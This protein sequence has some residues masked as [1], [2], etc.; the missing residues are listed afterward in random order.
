M[1]VRYG[2]NRQTEL[3]AN[4]KIL[5]HLFDYW[6]LRERFVAPLAVT[7]EGIEK[8]TGVPQK[9]IP[10]VMRKLQDEEY[11]EEKRA[12]VEGLTS[13]R[14]VY[15]LTAKGANRGSKIKK[16][17]EN[18]TVKFKDSNGKLEEITLSDVNKRIEPKL[19]YLEILNNLS[20]ECVFDPD[21]ILEDSEKKKIPLPVIDDTLR[22]RSRFVGRGEE[23][24]K[25]QYYADKAIEGHGNLVFITGEAGIGKTRLVNEMCKYAQSKNVRFLIGR[26]Q[27]Q[28]DLYPYMPFKQALKQYFES[29]AHS[30]MVK[31]GGVKISSS[32]IEKFLLLGIVPKVDAFGGDVKGSASSIL[33]EDASIQIEKEKMFETISQLFISIAGEKPLILFLDDLHDADNASLQ[34]LYYIAR[35]TR[36]SPILICCAYRPEDLNRFLEKA[37]PLDQLL[38]QMSRY[39]LFE[40][41]ALSRL[42]LDDTS[43]MIESWYNGTDIPH[44]F[45]K[46]IYKETD[47]NPFFI[48]EVLH[49]LESEGKVDLNKKRMNK[50]E[51]LAKLE[52]PPKIRDV[53]ARR[54]SR[55]DKKAIDI[56]Q[57]ASV[58]G[59]EFS[60]DILQDAAKIG[61]EELLG[62][63]GK[64]V[65]AELIQ[66][67]KQRDE[68]SYIFTHFKIR[69][70]VYDDL[71]R[72]E[73]LLMHEQIGNSIEK[74]YV[75]GIDEVL[76]DLSRHF[77]NSRDFEKA[78]NY[79]LKAGNKAKNLYALNEA[80]S[81]YNSALG[82][83]EK[84]KVTEKNTQKKMEILGNI[85]D[86]CYHLGN[87]D[88]ALN[89]YRDLTTLAN[90]MGDQIKRAKATRRIGQINKNKGDWKLAIKSFEKAL[91][92]SEE[93]NDTYG[94]ADAYAGIGS[95]L[96]RRGDYD[97]AIKYHEKGMEKAWEMGD[98]AEMA[99]VNIELGNV[100]TGKG[101][102]DKAIEYFE[103]CIGFLEKTGDIYEMAR[104]Y[105]NLGAV[106]KGKEEYDRAIVY[107]EK[108]VEISDKIGNLRGTAYGLSNIGEI[109]IKKL[110]SEK[111]K[112]YSSKALKLFE[113]LDDK[114]GVALAHQHFASAYKLEKQWEK[115]IQ[116]FNESIKIFE[117]LDLLQMLAPAYFEIGE[118]HES[119]RNVELGVEYLQKSQEIWEELGNKEMLNE[120]KN[121]LEV[122][123]GTSKRKTI[124]KS[125]FVGRNKEFKELTHHLEGALIGQGN[126]LFIEGEAG[127]GKSRLIEEFKQKCVHSKEILFLSGRC[128][129][130]DRIDPYL[131]FISALKEYIKLKKDWRDIGLKVEEAKKSKILS[132]TEL[133][134]LLTLL[135]KD[136]EDIIPKADAQQLEWKIDVQ[137]QK[138]VMFDAISSLI[139]KI[140]EGKTLVLFIDDIHW[141][142][143]ATLQLL[144]YVARSTRHSPVLICCTY[145]PEELR[146][147]EGKTH[148]L[149]DV[150]RQMNREGLFKT[151]TLERLDRSNVFVM[152]KNILNMK[153]IP[154]NFVELLHR[155][156][157]GNPFF[158]EE[159]LKSL[160]EEKIIDT[161]NN[162]WNKD[163]DK[164]EIPATIR[165]VITKRIS[166]LDEKSARILQYASVIGQQFDFDIL[167]DA[168]NIDRIELLDSLGKLIDNRMI[169]EDPLIEIGYKFDHA[170][171]RE[172]IYEAIGSRRELIHKNVGNAIE[173]LNQSNVERVIYDLAYHFFHAGEFEKA[174]NY[175]I[176]AGDKAIKTYAPDDASI[177]YKMALDSFTK[178]QDTKGNK[179]KKMELLLKM[180]DVSDI[181]G[182]WDDAL[183][184]YQQSMKFGKEIKNVLGMAESYRRIGYIHRNKSEWDSAIRNFKKAIILSESI[185][186]IHG[187]AN[188]CRGLGGVYRNKGEFE[189]A[190]RWNE[191]CVN[192]AKKIDDTIEIAKAYTAMGNAY[193]DKGELENAIKYH[194][195][196]LELLEKIDYMYEMA[197]SYNNLGTVYYDKEEL[198]KAIE[199]LEKSIEISGEIGYIRIKA[200]GLC[201]AGEIYA[202]KFNLNKAIDYTDKALEIFEKLDEKFMIGMCC[203]HYGIIYKLKKKWDKS[204]RY[205][206]EGIKILEELDIP[207][208]LALTHLEFALMYRDKGDMQNT[209][210]HLEKALYISQKLKDKEMIERI[211]KELSEIKRQ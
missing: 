16:H 133:S 89:Y 151:I 106:Y 196:S 149:T 54:I 7:Q 157:G 139:V 68:F 181:I 1:G 165:D 40:E 24:K 167:Q 128:S 21:K 92:I 193:R 101:E 53:I 146:E 64:L 155:E 20:D 138:S 154:E 178:L 73:K 113:K 164:I 76:D 71:K 153:E 107:F 94:I 122:I 96:W 117:E 160:I 135:I 104:A 84:V 28:W 174:A 129:H 75:E 116:E 31:V 124:S 80:F 179:Q 98:V 209:K 9:H 86:V 162:D 143:I 131:P 190:I 26:C 78:F 79:S 100:Y 47:G 13:K 132:L 39:N 29:R 186:D 182:K 2:G 45:Q 48:E 205:F 127:I 200:Y 50:L 166:R 15:F 137:Q 87:W 66:E 83:V 150:L 10:R 130:R 8:A 142:D 44:N 170:K 169:Y 208:E 69:E 103:K 4:E 201:N 140:A 77:V 32:D 43:K 159:V 36:Y 211:Q 38:L 177:Y 95:I 60:F 55:L 37:H 17:V 74:L 57:Y 18:I 70:V 5:L 134:P 204:I 63:L 56:L 14:K 46:L 81:Y 191:E 156:S 158:V 65:D 6:L 183:E 189:K 199:Y 91:Q 207:H 198:D 67:K 22:F 51:E 136:A 58:I 34:L 25:L 112:E 120:I 49:S 85:G 114:F 52:I 118:I 72:G 173:K 126:L 82:L 168:T 93:I 99:K 41:I 108:S 175:A 210:L 102:L 123:E 161:A 35:N 11:I 185:N 3:T 202:K 163:V 148:P 145:R 27:C 88:N 172:V 176:K 109:Y 115:A 111:A 97:S 171:I 110:R 141:A 90:E 188:A 187:I 42:T 33:N 194:K 125:S 192:K 147:I 59:E 121:R 62:L 105:N 30:K 197:I 61:N 195:K 23:F 152:I 144:H 19:T 184:Y 203:E 119:N 206:E 12:H 180:G